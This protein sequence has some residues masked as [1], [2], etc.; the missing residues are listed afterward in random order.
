MCENALIA[1]YAKQLQSVTPDIVE[2]I[3]TDFRLGVVCSSESENPKPLDE[4]DVRRAAQT[5]LDVYAS[6]QKPAFR[7]SELRSAITARVSKHESYI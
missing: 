7:K 4:T 1:A 5:L 2:E 6:L 3:A